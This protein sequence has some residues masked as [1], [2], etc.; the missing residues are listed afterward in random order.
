MRSKAATAVLAFALAAAALAVPAQASISSTGMRDTRYCEIFTIFLSPSPIAKVNNSYNL[1]NCR[2]GW[3]ESLDTGELAAESG[4]NLVT[5]NGPRYW[6]MDK[7]VVNE[8][9]PISTF[10]G[11]DF[12]EVATIDLTKVGLAPPP[13]YTQ[14]KI[15]RGTK[16]VFRR[17]R[18][19][20]ELTDPNGRHFVM[21]SYSQIVDSDLAYRELRGLGDRI[22]LPDGWSYRSHRPKKDIVLR[23]NGQATIVQDGL[24]NTYQRIHR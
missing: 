2:Q 18:P 10:A 24:K 15:Q 4:A 16:F 17:D 8:P 22:G 23:A 12:R 3:W 1:N 13:A 20:F 11:K 6:L 19:V 21:Q 5:L 7:V 14:V 9:G